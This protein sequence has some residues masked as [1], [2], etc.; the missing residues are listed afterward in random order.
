M[1]FATPMKST[2]TL[3]HS[4]FASADRTDDGGKLHR[5][6]EHKAVAI[7]GNTANAPT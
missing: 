5:K 6:A 7:P 4:A 2:F 3:L 1:K